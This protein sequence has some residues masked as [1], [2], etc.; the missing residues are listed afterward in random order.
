LASNEGVHEERLQSLQE[1]YGLNEKAVEKFNEQLDGNI[2][3]LKVLNAITQEDPFAKFR[4]DLE[5]NTEQIIDRYNAIGANIL[6][7]IAEIRRAITGLQQQDADVIKSLGLDGISQDEAIQAI[8]LLKEQLEDLENTLPERPAIEIRAPEEEV[9]LDLAG[10]ERALFDITRPRKIPIVPELKEFDIQADDQELQD[11]LSAGVDSRA[12]EQLATQSVVFETMLAN[13][14]SFEKRRLALT[15]E[16]IDTELALIGAG[17]DADRA[18][19]LAKTKFQAQ[20]AEQRRELAMQAFNQSVNL[21]S[22]F[23][24]ALTQLNQAQS[25]ET[26]K[27]ARKRFETQKKLSLS[28][29]IIDGISSAVGSFKVGARIGGPPLGAAFA[30]AS[31]A[32]TAVMIEAIRRQT[33]NSTGSISG[34]GFDV[35]QSTRREQDLNTVDEGPSVAPVRQEGREVTVNVVNTFDNRTVAKV[36]RDSQNKIQSNT[37]TV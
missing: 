9:M 24:S 34:G 11:A 22:G 8:L 20:Q 14:N 17:V 26:E 29:A 13:A 36:V 10:I 30:A 15:K 5:Q 7:T 3:R 31:T 25:D 33:F 6:P 4:E 2:E 37:F 27:Q 1:K 16:R 18:A 32:A 21:A 19:E 23:V 28:Q 35:S 12:Q